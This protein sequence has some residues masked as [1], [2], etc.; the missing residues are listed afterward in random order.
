MLP[1]LISD[2]RETL[3][4]GEVLEAELHVLPQRWR[5]PAFET[6]HIKEDPKAPVR[7]NKVVEFGHELIVIRFHQLSAHVDFKH[8][9]SFVR[10]EFNGHF[11][12]LGLRHLCCRRPPWRQV[13]ATPKTALANVEILVVRHAERPGDEDDLTPAGVARAAAYAK[14]FKSLILHG[15]KIHLTHLFAE[16]SVRTRRTLEPLSKTVD[17]PLDTR[18]ST[19]EYQALADDLRA[20]AYGKEILICWHHSKMADLIT[21]LGGMPDAVIPGGKWPKTTYDWIVDLRYD[22][23]GKLSA[24]SEKFVHG[25]LMPGDSK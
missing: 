2:H 20:H 25:H 22:E 16:K 15:E 9:P 24:A 18:F 5:F 23:S 14:Y 12:L 7:T 21:A 10:F 4:I 11:L 6:S 17:L 3:N 8:S 13:P 19:K 1:A